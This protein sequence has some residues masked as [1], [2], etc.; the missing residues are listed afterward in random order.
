[1][2]TSSISDIIVEIHSDAQFLLHTD[3]PLSV[4]E[5]NLS[6]S[7]ISV[8][9]ITVRAGLHFLNKKPSNHNYNPYELNYRSTSLCALFN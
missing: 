4:T 6:D 9:T 1:M 7:T 2:P 3:G 8:L 5:H